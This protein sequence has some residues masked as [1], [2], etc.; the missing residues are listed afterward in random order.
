MELPSFDG[1]DVCGWLSRAT[2][3]FIVNKTPINQRVDLA[4]NA[5]SGPVTPWIQLILRRC[6]NLSWDQFSQEL[7]IRFGTNQ[8]L[9]GYEALRMTRQEGTLDEYIT[10]FEG[11]LAQLPDLADHHYLNALQLAKRIDQM[12]FSAPSDRNQ[13]GFSKYGRVICLQGD[14]TLTRKECTVQELQALSEDD[15]CWMLWTMEGTISC[16]EMGISQTLPAADRKA[17]G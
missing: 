2:Q 9:D 14:P 3:Y 17:I 4:M 5:L 6:P 8:A 7:L 16:E 11:R 15:E 1:T 13:S 12:T 10:E